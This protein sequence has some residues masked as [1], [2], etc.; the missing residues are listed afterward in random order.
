MILRGVA[1][2][3]SDMHG[4][5]WL[6]ILGGMLFLVLGIVNKNKNGKHKTLFDLLP[7][8]LI[9]GIM[10]LGGIWSLIHRKY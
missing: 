1:H 6:P 8:L 10:I 3:A 9:C 5:E 2:T 7:L 4:F